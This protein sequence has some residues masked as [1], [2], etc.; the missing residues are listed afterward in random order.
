MKIFE[1]Q[2]IKWFSVSDIMKQKKEFRSFYQNVV[3]IIL[4][5]KKE[6]DL[7]IRKSMQTKDKSKTRKIRKRQG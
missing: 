4:Q 7:F 1:K 6:I 3:E 5:N 2:E